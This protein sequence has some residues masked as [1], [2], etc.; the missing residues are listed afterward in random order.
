MKVGMSVYSIVTLCVV[1]RMSVY[2]TTALFVV[3]DNECVSVCDDEDFSTSDTSRTF[4]INS[5]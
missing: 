3:D 2:M 1:M 4:T 5:W